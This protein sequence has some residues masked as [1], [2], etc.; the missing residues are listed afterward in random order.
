MS[1]THVV[2]LCNQALMK[3][4][5]KALADQKVSG[6]RMVIE[7]VEGS[8]DEETPASTVGQEIPASN[9]RT[10]NTT[11]SD[12]QTHEVLVDKTKEQCNLH[13]FEESSHNY[14]GGGDADAPKNTE[15][16][17][18]QSQFGV[19]GQGDIVAPPPPA[20]DDLPPA[21]LALKDA[22]NDLFRK[23][24]YADALD[25]YNVALQLLG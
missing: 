21:V 8:D 5:D 23:G 10:N 3:E 4:V 25:K 15:A 6:R 16:S 14:W 18:S 24:Q 22:G 9:D 20:D 12:D 2:C 1:I 19:S 7:E 11:N 13:D 17:G